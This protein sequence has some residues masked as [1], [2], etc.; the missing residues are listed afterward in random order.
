MHLC[1]CA[2]VCVSEYVCARVHVCARMRVCVNRGNSMKEQEV[3]EKHLRKKES[4][5]GDEAE[6]VPGAR[7]YKSFYPKSDRKRPTS[8]V[9]IRECRSYLPTG[10]CLWPPPGRTGGAVGPG[11]EGPLNSGQVTDAGGHYR[12]QTDQREAARAA[13][14]D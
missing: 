7:T 1:A 12:G 9:L 3:R 11:T 6:D 2:C 10:N 14:G 13:P 5:R 4:R 8:D